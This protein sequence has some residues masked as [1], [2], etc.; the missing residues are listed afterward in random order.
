MTQQN[1]DAVV[2]D[3]YLKT[4]QI[5]QATRAGLAKTHDH[6]FK[7]LYAP[8]QYEP[9]TLVIGAQPGGD[10]THMLDAELRH[11]SVRNEYL[12]Q[13][14]PL[15][16]ELRKRFG[17]IFLQG[18]IGT[19]AIFFRAPSWNTWLTIDPQLRMKLENF[20]VAENKR[21][22]L[23]MRPKQILLLG[24][25]ALGLM[26]GTGFREL[27]ANRPSDGRPRRKRLLMFGD[28]AGVP[29]F[30]IPHPTAAWK[31]PPVSDVDWAMIVAK[32]NQSP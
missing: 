7:I 9:S 13:S 6:G 22:I 18:A 12:S 29:A 3:I 28:I 30:A 32:I 27:V 19:N 11:P 23:A 14:W 15:A 31:N 4:H 26:G 1:L 21:L 25:D 20:C 24:W 8:A 10:A 2:S 5:W 16:S 17:T